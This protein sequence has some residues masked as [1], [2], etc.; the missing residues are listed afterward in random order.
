MWQYGTSWTAPVTKALP[1]EM[2]DA[3]LNR[4]MKP[5]AMTT[6]KTALQRDTR[7]VL[8]MRKA[9]R[10]VKPSQAHCDHPV[11]DEGWAP[12]VKPKSA[13]PVATAKRRLAGRDL[14][15]LNSTRWLDSF[16]ASGFS[17]FRAIRASPE[18]AVVFLGHEQALALALA[19]WLFWTG[20]GS[21]SQESPAEEP[22]SMPEPKRKEDSISLRNSAL[23]VLAVR[24]AK[25]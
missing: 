23:T 25:T 16:S 22:S 6:K 13:Q 4:T 8:M 17:G 9:M 1:V 11:L 10:E 3:A 21:F 15:A 12:K 19:S 5:K 14:A 2:M 24:W 18:L 20:L 7:P